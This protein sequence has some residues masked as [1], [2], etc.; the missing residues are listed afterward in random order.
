[1]RRRANRVDEN[2]AVI[3]KALRD[4]GCCVLDLSAVHGGCPDLAVTEPVYPF[5]TLLMEIKNPEK[6]KADQQLTTDQLKF[7]AAW[8]GRIAI[9][10]TVD[11]ALRAVR[12]LA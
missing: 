9:V 2:Q 3:C 6:P 5:D 1:M 4:A 7:H 11:E 10:R 8:K 12:V